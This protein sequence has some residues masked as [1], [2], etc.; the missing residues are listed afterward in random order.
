MMSM[1]TMNRMIDKATIAVR[2]A[3]TDDEYRAAVNRLDELMALRKEMVESRSDTGY[4]YS[5]LAVNAICALVPAWL[6]VHV[7][8]ECIEFEDTGIWSH[9]SIKGLVSKI[10]IGK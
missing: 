7:L 1:I 5:T 3:Q 4:K 9:P 8:K 10:R 6:N 2:D